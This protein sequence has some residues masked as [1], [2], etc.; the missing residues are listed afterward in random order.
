VG[1]RERF[2][3]TIMG[4]TVNLAHRLQEANRHYG[5]RLIISDAARSR[6]GTGFLVRELDRVRVRGRVQP[7]T[8]FELVWAAPGEPTPLWLTSF[9]K[10]REAYL[11]RDW[12]QATLSFE[13]VIRLKPA[14]GPAALY[15]RRCRRHLSAPPPPDWEGVSVLD[16]SHD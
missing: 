15:L 1:S 11:E 16:G 7:V 10:G 8:I 3:Y 9:Q 4:D 2:N 5:T 6:A 13:E 12:P 14:D